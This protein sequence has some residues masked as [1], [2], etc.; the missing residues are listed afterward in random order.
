VLTNPTAFRLTFAHDYYVISRAGADWR[1]VLHKGPRPGE[2]IYSKAAGELVATVATRSAAVLTVMDIEDATRFGVGAADGSY[3]IEMGNN[4]YFL[5]EWDPD[6]GWLFFDAYNDRPA[7]INAA[8]QQT[9][10]EWAQE[11]QS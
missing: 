5:Y 3:L 8:L 6:T 9:P 11:V 7:A 4:G 10:V 1:V 2:T